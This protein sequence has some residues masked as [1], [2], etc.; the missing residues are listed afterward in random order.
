MGNNYMCVL[1]Y[2]ASKAYLENGITLSLTGKWRYIGQELGVPDA[3]LDTC[4]KEPD[5]DYCFYK[6]L[7]WWRE[8]DCPK[9]FKLFARALHVVGCHHEEDELL[10]I[11]GIVN[12]YHVFYNTVDIDIISVNQEILAEKFLHVLFRGCLISPVTKFPNLQCI[13]I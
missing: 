9:S 11:H 1:L 6:M 12:N 10:A 5:A 3:V 7:K 2:S 4:E 8:K 13:V